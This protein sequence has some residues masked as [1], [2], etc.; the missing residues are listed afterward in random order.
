MNV[1]AQ[2]VDN[3]FSL[4][5]GLDC[6][7]DTTGGGTAGTANAWTNN[8]GIDDDPDGICIDPIRSL[9]DGRRV[10]LSRLS[11]RQVPAG[12]AVSASVTARTR[13]STT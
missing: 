2:F 11:T 1:G 12:R 7:D 13:R 10:R 5:T 6:E 4:N 3:D 8:L 9:S